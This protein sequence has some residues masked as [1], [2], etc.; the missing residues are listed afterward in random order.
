ML[1]HENPNATLSDDDFLARYEAHAV[2]HFSHED[3]VRMAFAYATRGGVAAAVR[4]ARRIRD[5]AETLGAPDK[6]HDTLTVAWARI[7]AQLAVRSR[8]TTFE[9][10]LDAHPELLRRD[11]LAAHYT[12][13]VLF[14]PAAR[15]DF[16]EPDLAPL[17]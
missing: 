17:P 12:H 16:V 6:Y 9:E 7:V 14:S 4:G 15:A 10:F 11:L 2:E 8:A 5:L 1:A 3:H 13:G